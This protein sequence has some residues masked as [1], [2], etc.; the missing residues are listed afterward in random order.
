MGPESNPQAAIDAH[1]AAVI[2]RDLAAYSATLHPDVTVVI[3]SGRVMTGADE[4]VAFHS[5]WFAERDWTYHITHVRSVTTG[6]SAGRVVEVTYVDTPD[7]E[8]SRFVMGLVFVRHDNR[9]L[10]IHD[11]CTLLRMEE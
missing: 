11:Q 8:P 7:A 5:A 10:L 6:D 4:V 2:E 9:W 1:L 3:P